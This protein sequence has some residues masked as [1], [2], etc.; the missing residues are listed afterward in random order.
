MVL[1][2]SCSTLRAILTWLWCWLTHAPRWELD[3][4]GYGVDRLMLHAESYTDLAMVL[5]DS[6]STLRAR[7]TW[8]WCWLTHAPHWELYWPGY[9]VDW[10]MLHI[11]SYTD[12]AMVLT[13]SCFTLRATL[14]W[15]WCWPTHAPRW[16]LVPSTC[17]VLVLLQSAPH[18]SVKHGNAAWRLSLLTLSLLHR[19]TTTIVL[20]LCSKQYQFWIWAILPILCEIQNF[21]STFPPNISYPNQRAPI[22]ALNKGRFCLKNKLE[23]GLKVTKI[24]PNP[25]MVTA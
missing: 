5:S 6:C 2:D 16:E 9:G 18:Q 3:W 13:D 17:P 14:T 21:L 11:E 25:V 15:L 8:L 23:L 7:L 12:L 4:P 1:T 22:W 24:P 19:T 10:L 20:I